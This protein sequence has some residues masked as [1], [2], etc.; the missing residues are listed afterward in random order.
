MKLDMIGIVTQDMGRSLAF[1]RRLG[2]VIPE[3]LENE[4]H[5]EITLENGLRFAWDTLELMQSLVPNF[6]LH[7]H[8]V[9]AF[10]CSSAAD[11][12]AKYHELTQAGH[13]SQRES[14]DAFWG[15]RYAIIQDPDGHTVDLFAPLEQSVS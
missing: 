7:P 9:G 2:W 14:W 4:A 11:V 8:N 5:V 12:D 13:A 15:Q 6:V 10:L 1:Y 3:G